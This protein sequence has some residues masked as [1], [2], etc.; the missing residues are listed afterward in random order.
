ML[1]I[2]VFLLNFLSFVHRHSWVP[3]SHLNFLGLAFKAYFEGW[4][5]VSWGLII[6][7]CWCKSLLCSLPTAMW[8]MGFSRLAGGN[9]GHLILSVGLSLVSQVVTSHVCTD[10]HV[11]ALSSQSGGGPFRYLQYVS[12]LFASLQ[13][14]VLWSLAL[15]VSPHSQLCLLVSGCLLGP[16]RIPSPWVVSWKLFQS[17]KLE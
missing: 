12:A 7:H 1:D 11:C 4:A 9:T 17:N 3:W 10:H 2:F 13:C 15:L 16:I 14:S 6:P 5:T 8:I